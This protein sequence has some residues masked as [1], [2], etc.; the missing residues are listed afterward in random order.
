MTDAPIR[1][2]DLVVKRFEEDSVWIRQM[3]DAARSQSTWI[4]IWHKY[5][6]VNVVWQR[7]ENSDSDDDDG[8]VHH[9]PET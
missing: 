4:T 8:Q 2:A 9:I 6:S 3:V 5:H 7:H 1:C